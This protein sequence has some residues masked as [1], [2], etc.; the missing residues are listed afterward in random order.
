VRPAALALRA[1]AEPQAVEPV[2]Q[3]KGRQTEVGT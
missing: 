2:L 1:A 3:W